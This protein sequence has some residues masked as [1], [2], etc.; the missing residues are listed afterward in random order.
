VNRQG[1]QSKV[2]RG[3]GIAA[4]FLG[5]PFAHYRPTDPLNALSNRIGTLQAD[6][7][8]DPTFSYKAPGKYANPAYYG[9][10]DATD[11]MRGDYLIADQGT[12]FVAGMEPNKPPLCVSCNQVAEFR[13]PSAA[14]A[15]PSYYGGDNRTDE[16]VLMSGWPCSILQGTKGERTAADLPGDSRAPW[17]AILVPAVPGVVLRPFDRV[18][19]DMNR[20]WTISGPERTDLG[21]R[22]TAAY[23]GA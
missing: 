23:T 20:C 16:E 17:V 1:I 4:R 10:F 9:L 22:L 11:V 12:W 13:R 19:D 6:F 5:A 21:W 14:A 8:V 2:N 7:D 3:Y 18:Y 15:G